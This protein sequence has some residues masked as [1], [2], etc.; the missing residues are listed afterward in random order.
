[1]NEVKERR[2]QAKRFLIVLAAF[3]CSAPFITAFGPESLPHIQDFWNPGSSL[4]VVAEALDHDYLAVT[5]KKVLRRGG[6]VSW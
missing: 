1:M 3:V 4:N 6:K 5:S 2:G